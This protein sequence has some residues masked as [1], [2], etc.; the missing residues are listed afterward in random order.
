MKIAMA[1]LDR[2]F[3]ALRARLVRYA[4]TMLRDRDAAEDLVQ[5][6]LLTVFERRSD[7]RGEASLA[8]WAIGILKHKAA[9]WHRSHH[10]SELA[11]DDEGEPLVDPSH[12][13]CAR[14]DHL[15][16]CLAEA[17]EPEGAFA[18][19]E[20]VAAIDHCVS[21]LPALAAQ[22]FVLHECFGCDTGEVCRRLAISRDN[23]RTMLHRARMSLRVC[24]Q[25]SG[26]T[27]H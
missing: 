21:R 13:P 19:D 11:L 22:V 17:S 14:C 7:W 10:R 16:R 6:T 15:G 24:L 5:D 2:E 3:S 1:A 26:I 8:T 27:L 18:R 20:L 9:D 23:C 12:P 25:T 4:R